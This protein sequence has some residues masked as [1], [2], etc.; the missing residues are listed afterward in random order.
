MDI[1]LWKLKKSWVLSVTVFLSGPVDLFLS[2]LFTQT[3][4]DGTNSHE[5]Q[6]QR[7]RVTGSAHALN[8]CNEIG[9]DRKAF[10]DW[11]VTLKR[12]GAT[13]F[14]PPG[15]WHSLTVRSVC[16]SYQMI[17]YEWGCLLQSV[18]VK[19]QG[20]SLFGW[21]GEELISGGG[22]SV[23]ML[24]LGFTKMVKLCSSHVFIM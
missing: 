9:Q 21:Q 10:S 6:S 4:R 18:C 24:L 15:P 14:N 5:T 11:S 12:G 13:D 23:R 7:C 2:L 3:S 22:A 16:K 8:Q 20:E 1:V 19:V 17:W